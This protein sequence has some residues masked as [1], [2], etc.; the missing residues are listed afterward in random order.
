[1]IS[2]SLQG[3]PPSDNHAYENIPVRMIRGKPVGGGRR[4]TEEGRTY[5][6]ETT[7]YI[8]RHYTQ[9]LARFKKNTPYI[10]WCVFYFDHLENKGWPKKTDTR[11]KKI[12]GI[13]HT[14]LLFDVLAELTGCD[15]STFMDAIISKREGD[16]RVEVTFWD[17]ERE[18]VV[19]V[20][21]KEA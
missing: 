18:E 21:G 15:D 17:A 10:L 5:K 14:K 2:F 19:L 4:L 7:N 20:L 1:M 11:Y 9:D 8:A 13:N 3:L 12:D 16:E 6:V